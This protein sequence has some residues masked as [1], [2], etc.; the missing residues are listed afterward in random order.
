VPHNTVS[1][2][3]AILSRAGLITVQRHSRSMIYRVELKAVRKLVLF[4][5]KDCCNGQLAGTVHPYARWLLKLLQ[6]TC[7]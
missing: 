3:L 1:T 6:L 4:P 2:H 7:H 5:V